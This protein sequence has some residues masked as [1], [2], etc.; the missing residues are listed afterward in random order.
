MALLVPPPPPP[1]RSPPLDAMETS[2]G[3]PLVVKP[4]RGE[5]RAHVELLVKKKRRIK[6]KA[7][8]PPEGSSPAQ[9]KVMKLGVPDPRLCSQV[10][11]RGQA[12]FSSTEVSEV[13]GVKLHSSSATGVKGS[14][15]KAAELPL[16][17]LP[18]YVWIPLAQNASPSPP[19]RGGVGDDRFEA[20]GGCEDSLL[21]NA[22]LTTGAVSSIL[23][24]SDLRKVAAL[25]VENARPCPSKGP[26]LYV[27]C[28]LL[29]VLSLC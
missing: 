18:I 9:G 15:R 2:P 12:W 29:F 25:R 22:E 14:L 1:S 3:G 7:Q 6:P 4:T 20:E 28:L 24:N 16:K 17:V 21:I 11:V 19:T 10:Q 5:L 13:G 23:R 8:D 27:A 26:S